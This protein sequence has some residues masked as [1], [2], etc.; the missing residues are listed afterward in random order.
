[1]AH[2]LGLRVVAEGVETESVASR[3]RGL[4]CD[5]AQGYL[6]SRPLVAAEFLA[7]ARAAQGAANAPAGSGARGGKMHT[8]IR[9]RSA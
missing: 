4:G 2:H 5:E 1:M 9:A 6:F 3:L 8:R 7:W